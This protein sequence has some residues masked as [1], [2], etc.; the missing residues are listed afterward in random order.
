MN[1][2]VSQGI[3]AELG[4]YV[5]QVAPERKAVNVASADVVFV[6]QVFRKS[7]DPEPEALVAAMVHSVDVLV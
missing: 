5:K 7:T 2:D 4:K 6:C 1:H 3:L